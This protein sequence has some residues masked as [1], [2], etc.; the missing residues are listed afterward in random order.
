[1]TLAQRLLLAI[2]AVTI[3]TA[4]T[5]GFF[6]RQ[7]WRESEER[8]FEADYRDVVRR[9]GPQL[10]AAAGDVES[11]VEFLCDDDSTVD[12]ALVAL[13]AGTLEER[14]L[15]L[16]LLVPKLA[17]AHRLD[18]LVLVTHTGE[19][20]GAHEAGLVG[21][22]APA[23]VARIRRGGKVTVRET[24]PFAFE[25]ACQHP[26]PER[27][28]ATWVGLYAA[29]HIDSL[30]LRVGESAGVRLKRDGPSSAP[31]ELTEAIV[32]DELPRVK[33][34]AS[35]D[36]SPVFDALGKLDRTLFFVGGSVLAAAIVVALLA[37]RGLARPIVE[38]SRQ[39]REI[40]HG[41]PKPVVG[42]GGR[43]LEE[44][45]DV[46]NRAIAD[47]AQLRRR[48]AAAERIAAR[49]EIAR[50][51]AHEIK[52]PLAPIR[53]AVETLRRLR[54]RADPAFEEYFDE[55]TRTVLDE[56]ARISHIVSEFTR[57]ARLPPPNP[58]P[59]DLVE[60][61]RSVVGLHA[62][63]SATLTLDADGALPIVADRDQMVQILTNLIQNALDAV[64]DTPS[65]A[66]TVEVKR[67]GERARLAVRDNGPG[68]SAEVRA[69]LFEPYLT[70][71][72]DGTG[73]GLAIVQRIVV[74]HGGDIALAEEPGPGATLIVDLPLSGPPAMPEREPP[75][76]S[77]QP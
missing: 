61:A 77:S 55:A 71:K 31:N 72:A 6:F 5:A 65:P 24:P 16:R 64:R 35:R 34:W 62:T 36:R 57:F 12:G 13:R 25:Y 1:V 51:V 60:A 67:R 26:G 46:Y 32:I 43:E 2:A 63:G 22:R 52:N 59:M 49:R 69:H 29:K 15:Q 58:A 39:A 44:F 76:S 3:A 23:L 33:I 20:L 17:T 9:L 18:E 48:L 19:V 47:L 73:L 10:A 38:M 21:Q 54:A 45:A 56:V 50:R 27:R 40:V 53:A 37:S 75:P 66:V 30:L 74:E 70:T 68:F 42:G 14:R 8:R 4:A 11:L 41:E 7:A 28:E